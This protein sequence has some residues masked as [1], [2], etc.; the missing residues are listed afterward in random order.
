MPQHRVLAGGRRRIPTG[1]SYITTAIPPQHH[2]QPSPS[3][4]CLAVK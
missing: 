4:F 3:T 1:G 2:N